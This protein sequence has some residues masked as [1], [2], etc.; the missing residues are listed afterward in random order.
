M[1]VTFESWPGFELALKSFDPLRRGTP[2][3]LPQFMNV[4]PTKTVCSSRQCMS[5]LAASASSSS[6][7]ISTP[8]ETHQRESLAMQT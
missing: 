1:L 7:L 4:E 3:L 8:H 5:L 6:A 2:E